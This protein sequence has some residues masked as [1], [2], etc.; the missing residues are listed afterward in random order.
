MFL[1][2]FTKYLFKNN[3]VRSWQFCAEFLFQSAKLFLN[4]C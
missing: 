2:H 1:Y 3:L 4:E